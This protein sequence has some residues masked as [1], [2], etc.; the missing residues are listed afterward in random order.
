MAKAKESAVIRRARK[1]LKKQLNQSQLKLSDEALKQMRGIIALQIER[2]ALEQ[3]HER[4]NIKSLNIKSIGNKH[5]K[6][7]TENKFVLHLM[8][9]IRK[10]AKSLPQLKGRIRSV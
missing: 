9:K 1:K 5:I 3:T 8:E 4:I 10:S 2:S 6:A 7:K